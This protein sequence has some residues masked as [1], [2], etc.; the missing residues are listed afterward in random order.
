[1]AGSF[2]ALSMPGCMH[3]FYE[4]QHNTVYEPQHVFNHPSTI[5]KTSTAHAYTNP[6]TL[7]IGWNIWFR[8]YTLQTLAHLLT[9]SIWFGVYTL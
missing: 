7:L 4:P 2:L 1:M 5:Y 9:G 6:I 8:F 3:V